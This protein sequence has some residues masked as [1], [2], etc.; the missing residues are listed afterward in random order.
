MSRSTELLLDDD[1]QALLFPEPAYREL[2]VGV[3]DAAARE[4]RALVFDDR[5]PPVVKLGHEIGI[6]LAARGWQPERLR[7]VPTANQTLA[8]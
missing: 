8:Y 5:H 7:V 2:L 4:Q 3:V 6:E 1:E